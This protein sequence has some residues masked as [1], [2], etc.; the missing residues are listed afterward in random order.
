MV[1]DSLP[2]SID[3]TES[4][5]VHGS[6]VLVLNRVEGTQLLWPFQAVP[7]PPFGQVVA[8]VIGDRVKRKD[9]QTDWQE[10][11]LDARRGSHAREHVKAL[12]FEIGK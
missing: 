2:L 10:K 5:R 8:Q 1:T 12:G 4:L 7:D 3:D 9:W 6:G 11:Y